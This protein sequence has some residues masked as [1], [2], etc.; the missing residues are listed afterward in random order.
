[1]M[2]GLRTPQHGHSLRLSYLA[3]EIVSNTAELLVEYQTLVLEQQGYDNPD[4]PNEDD[5]ARRKRR[6]S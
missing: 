3:R 4:A 5:R 2:A 6:H 1:M